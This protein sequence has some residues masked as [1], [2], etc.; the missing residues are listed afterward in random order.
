MMS[1]V[2]NQARID[3]RAVCYDCQQRHDIQAVPTTWLDRMSEWEVKH[4]GHRIE[5]QSPRRILAKG[6]K[7]RWFYTL[8]DRW[9]V[10]PWWADSAQFS[11]N[12]DFK[13]AYAAHA[14]FTITLASLATSA[15]FTA[16]K[17]ARRV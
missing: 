17:T 15:T 6:L 12:V 1:A 10:L 5:F 13:L 16:W 3:L 7:D 4:R 9:G 11:P 2:G 14:D 8:L